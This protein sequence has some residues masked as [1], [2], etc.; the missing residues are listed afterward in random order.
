MKLNVS[1]G[2][3]SS[4]LLEEVEIDEN[5]KNWVEL[6]STAVWSVAGL[7]SIRFE[8]GMAMAGGVDVGEEGRRIG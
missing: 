6:S 2:A 3:E 5:E 1:S 4:K 8:K 7:L